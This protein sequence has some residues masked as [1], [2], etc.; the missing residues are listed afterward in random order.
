MLYAQSLFMICLAIN[1]LEFGRNA[2]NPGIRENISITSCMRHFTL[3]VCNPEKA[4]E[5][6]GINHTCTFKDV[7]YAI[8]PSFLHRN[9]EDYPEI[10]HM[11]Q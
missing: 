11:G 10:E 4:R 7:A 2:S 9:I 8:F 3:S 6:F 5:E 1:Q